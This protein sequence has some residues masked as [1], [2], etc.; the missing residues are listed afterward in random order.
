MHVKALIPCGGKGTR[1]RPL[2]HT[3]AKPLVPVANKP[4][5]HYILEQIVE[6]GITD[7]GIVVSPENLLYFR[8][9]LGDGARWGSKISYIL[10]REQRGLADTVIQAKEFLEESSFLMFLGDNL[11]QKGIK[12]IVN[13][14][15][16]S[17]A[18][19]I[20]QLKSVEDPR[21]FGV[22]IIDE[23][24]RIIRLFEKPQVPPSN[25]AVV[26]VYL[27][28]PVIHQAVNG[29]IPSKRGELEITDA[30]QKL[31]DLN[32]RVEARVMDGWWLDTGRKEELLAANRIILEEQT[33]LNIE[34][35][36]DQESLLKGPVEL[37]KG[38]KVSQS[39]IC[40]PVRIGENVTV[41]RS[42]I[43]PHTSIGSGTILNNVNLQYSVVMEN[44][45]LANIDQ[46]RDS[47]IGYNCKIERSLHVKEPLNL[48]IGDNCEVL[49]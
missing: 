40:G 25:L 15:R 39:I 35:E 33:G 18:D 27:F 8:E 44:C 6:A 49:L 30:I 21:R 28:R 13:E 16:D 32:C 19:A 43:G 31:V 9:A 42:Y 14:F 2:T 23:H 34:G 1:L 24:N 46:L 41:H 7:I 47:I 36:V 4:I 26:G 37:G 38:S 48:L 45:Q 10:Q 11:I 22:A 17:N 29:I 20:I 12:E 5:L 3:I